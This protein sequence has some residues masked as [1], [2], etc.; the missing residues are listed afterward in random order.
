MP[1]QPYASDG[2][3]G[4]IGLN[5]RENPNTLQQ[6]FVT[7][8]QNFRFNR[9]I[10]EVRKG[11][12]R[13]TF[14]AITNQTVFG[15]CVYVGSNGAEQFVIVVSDGLYLYNTDTDSPS[16]KVPFPANETI[17]SSDFVEVYQATGNGYVYITRG[18]NKTVLRWN[19]NVGAGNIMVPS[20]LTHNNYPNSKTA[21]YYGNRHIVQIDDNTIRVSHYLEDDKWSALDMFS[22]NDGSNDRLVAITPWTLNEFVIFM[23][24]SIF[25]ASVGVGAYLLSD[26]ATEDNSYVKSLA[27]DIGCLARKSIVQAGGGIIFLSDNGVYLLNP[28]GA[29]GASQ[30]APEGMRLL[31]LSEPLSAQIDD[32]ITRINQDY[33]SEAVAVYWENRYYLAVPLDNSETNNAI[34]VFNFI[35]KSWESVDIYPAGFDV[36]RFLIGKKNNKRRLWAVDPNEGV[37]LLEELNWD[38]FGPSVGTPVLNSEEARLDSEGCRLS[39]TAYTPNSINAELITRAYV[40]QTSG[41]KRFSSVQSDVNFPAFGQIDVDFITTN[42]DTSTKLFEFSPSSNEDYILRLPSR[43]VAYSAQVKYSISSY[44]PS[45]RSVSVDAILVGHN[46]HTKP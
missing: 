19:G 45:I 7:K 20:N 8:S 21:I 39:A 14:S 43:K 28:S 12:K 1:A 11:A 33:A 23:R 2:D 41:D 13:Y 4:F 26:P 29:A 17:D 10:A 42:P 18:F 24:N 32:V 6:G 27:T 30:A 16:A 34:L 25:Y 31:T 9:G 38:E 40:F 36:H 46:I 44:R 35:N 22:I 37:F 5:S 15:S 3:Q